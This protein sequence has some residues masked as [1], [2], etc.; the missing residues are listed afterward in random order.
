MGIGDNRRDNVI[1]VLVRPI[2]TPFLFPIT[3]KKGDGVLREYA[4]SLPLELA[5]GIDTVNSA[6]LQWASD[7]VRGVRTM[8]WVQPPSPPAPKLTHMSKVPKPI[9][10]GSPSSWTLSLKVR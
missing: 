7:F 8:L 1:A 10:K 2:V 9:A 5:Q 6:Q 4:G 3:A